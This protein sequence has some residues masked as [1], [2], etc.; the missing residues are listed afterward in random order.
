MHDLYLFY[1]CCWNLQILLRSADVG[2]C[3][4]NRFTYL[5]KIIKIL[6]KI[7]KKKI[8]QSLEINHRQKTILNFT[9]KIKFP[10]R[11]MIVLHWTYSTRNS[12]GIV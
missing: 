3:G 12:A 2:Y 10:R 4:V 9:I 5:L 6:D 8:V 11:E 7:V 1:F